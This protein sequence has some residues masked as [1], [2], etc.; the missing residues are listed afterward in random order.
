M[1]TTNDK[2]GKLL[3][4][5]AYFSQ[6]QDKSKWIVVLMFSSFYARGFFCPQTW[7][8]QPT[9]E[10][11]ILNNLENARYN[12]CSHYSFSMTADWIQNFSHY[13]Q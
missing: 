10:A 7:G 12:W 5:N 13:T 8:M 9:L 6:K 3:N 2:A 4:K 1:C 11:A